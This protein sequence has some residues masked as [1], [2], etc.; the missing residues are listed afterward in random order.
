MTRMA[1]RLLLLLVTMAT[2]KQQFPIKIPHT[3]Q[4][5]TIINTTLLQSTMAH[6][7]IVLIL[8]LLKETV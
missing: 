8:V 1:I 7:Q 2:T 6:L 3:H 5:L 4:M